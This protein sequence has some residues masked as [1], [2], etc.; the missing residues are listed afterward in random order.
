MKAW[1]VYKHAH[2]VL[3]RL[4]FE[5]DIKN[6]TKHNDLSLTQKT[7]IHFMLFSSFH[8]AMT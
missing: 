4:L 5:H 2:K 8:D 6:V 1:I 3:I 7:S